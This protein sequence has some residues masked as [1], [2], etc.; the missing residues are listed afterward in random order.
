[1][2]SHRIAFNNTEVQ[3]EKIFRD[4]AIL[5]LLAITIIAGSAV[6]IG[7]LW[8]DVSIA[9]SQARIVVAEQEAASTLAETELLV[10]S[11]ERRGQ[12][13]LSIALVGFVIVIILLVLMR[14]N[15]II[16]R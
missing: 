10:A 12:E 7:M 14:P 16:G 3:R 6:L 8:R 1:M 13:A 9:E 5:A 11:D 4:I 15:V 2:R